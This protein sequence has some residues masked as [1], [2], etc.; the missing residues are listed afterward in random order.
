MARACPVVLGVPPREAQGPRFLPAPDRIHVAGPRRESAGPAEDQLEPGGL[1]GMA[2]TVWI[3][4]GGA[5]LV[6]G[7]AFYLLITTDAG[8]RPALDHIDAKS[9]EEMDRLLRED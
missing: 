4:V 1:S 3:V 2:R 8:D 7:I 9:R 5:L 6:A